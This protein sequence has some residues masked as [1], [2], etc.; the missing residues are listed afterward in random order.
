VGVYVFSDTSPSLRDVTDTKLDEQEADPAQ[1]NHK[2]TECV[3]DVSCEAA[4]PVSRTVWNNFIANNSRPSR[5]APKPIGNW[6]ILRSTLIREGNVK[7]TDP[8]QRLPVFWVEDQ[9]KGVADFG[10]VRVFKRAHDYSVADVLN[11]T[12]NGAHHLDIENFEPD[13]VEALF[14]FVHEP[15]DSGSQKEAKKHA[16]RHLKGR[17]AFGFAELDGATSGRESTIVKSAMSAPKPSFGP[18]YLKSSEKKDW[19]GETAELAGRK[20][21]PARGADNSAVRNWLEKEKHQGNGNEDTLSRMIFLEPAGDATLN[22]K[23]RITVHN[24]TPVELG[25]LL[26]CLTFGG[27]DSKRHMIGRAKTAGAGQARISIART[28][29]TMN[30][31]T[32]VPDVAKLFRDYMEQ[33]VPGWSGFAPIADLLKTASPE[34]GE[35]LK[36]DYLGLSE[37]SKLRKKIYKSPEFNAGRPRLLLP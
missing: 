15:E 19:S 14:G 30:D 26:W 18:F 24:V 12:G 1:G 22:F 16:K 7:D 4:I 5:R 10:L 27:D 29:L 37:H 11:R 20:R 25:A 2:K 23:T 6:G 33:E 17:V 28:N 31:G 34:R 13:F 8:P 35:Q 9:E 36:L 3:F 32:T 21:Y